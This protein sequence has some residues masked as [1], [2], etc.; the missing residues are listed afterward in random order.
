MALQVWC[1]VSVASR[2]VFG[3]I[4]LIVSSY[5]DNAGKLVFYTHTTSL[6]ARVTHP[7]ERRQDPEQIDSTTSF[8]A[9]KR[10]ASRPRITA[11]KLP[12][13]FVTSIIKE[14]FLI[15]FGTTRKRNLAACGQRR[16]ELVAVLL[17]ALRGYLCPSPLITAESNSR[18]AGNNT[19]Q[20]ETGSADEPWCLAKWETAGKK[21]PGVKKSTRGLEKFERCSRVRGV[22]PVKTAPRSSFEGPVLSVGPSRGLRVPRD[23]S[24]RFRSAAPS[25]RADKNSFS[26][27]ACPDFQVCTW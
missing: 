9:R 5:V 27:Q 11:K 1:V 17:A 2:N 6:R 26:G 21:A 23:L 16:G 24:A 7:N 13:G 19:R 25:Y 3:G 15:L 20:L 18:A 14:R 4:L 8:A 22:Q 12:P 10:V